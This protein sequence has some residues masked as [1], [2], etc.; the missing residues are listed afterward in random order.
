MT[1]APRSSGPS[2]ALTQACPQC[3]AARLGDEPAGICPRCAL[4]LALAPVEDEPAAFALPRPFGRYELLEVIGRGG[5]GVVYR[6]RDTQLGRLVALKMLRDG[7][8]A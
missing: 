2:P 4:G 8:L 1:T 5:M 6:A 7:S 3:G